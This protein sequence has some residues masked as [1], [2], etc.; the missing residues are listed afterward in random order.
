M[1][2]KCNQKESILRK[3]Q[4]QNGKIANWLGKNTYKNHI[5]KPNFIL[6]TTI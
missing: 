1:S 5:Y 3:A 6:K 2:D 4:F